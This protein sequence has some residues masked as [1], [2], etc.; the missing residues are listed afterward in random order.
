MADR[1]CRVGMAHRCSHVATGF[2]VGGAHPTRAVGKTCVVNKCS[3]K[4]CRLVNSFGAM[5]KL[6]CPCR[7]SRVESG[8]GQTSLSMAPS[9]EG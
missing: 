9:V 2:S 3:V 1:I 7:K 5:D 4:L 6:V 8:H